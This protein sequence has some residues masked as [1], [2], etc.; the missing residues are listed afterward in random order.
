MN[1]RNEIKRRIVELLLVYNVEHILSHDS[2]RIAKLLVFKFFVFYLLG[3]SK[4]QVGGCD[5]HPILQL[6]CAKSLD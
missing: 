2:G 3:T 5:K 1:C 4:S 6:G